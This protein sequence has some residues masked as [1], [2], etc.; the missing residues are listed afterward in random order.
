MPTVYGDY[1]RGRIGWFFGLSGAQ[2]GILAVSVLPVFWAVH[3]TAWLSAALFLV[4]WGLVAVVTVVPVRGRSATGWLAASTG[5]A[6]GG[7]AGWTRFRS[8]AASGRA[9]PSEAPDLPGVLQGVQIHD[10]P[11][12]GPRLARVAII[13][14]HAARTWAVTAG[15]VHPGIGLT[16][17]AGRDR[18]GVGLSGLLDQACRTELVDEILFI[19]RTVPEDGA[20]RDLWL[21]RHRRPGAPRL[22]RGVNDDL[23]QALAQA[24]VR[25]ETFATVVVPESRIGR[26][27]RESGGGLE[28]RARV[29]YG[30]VEEVEAQLRGPMAMTAVGWLSSAELAAACRTGFAPGDRA[31]I[32]DAL[33]AR[34]GGQDIC[35]DVPWAIAGPSGAD[36]AP[37]HYS[38]DAWHSASITIRLPARGAVMGALA[39][40]L[41]PS[42]PGERRSVLVAYPILRQATADRVTA[43]AEWA[44]DIGTH[45][46]ARAGIRPRA[47]QREEAARAHGMDAKLAGGN[48]MTRP[49]AVCTVTV[50]RTARIAEHARRLD[51]AARR[52]GFAPLRLDLSQD[53][54]FAASTIPLGVS[55]TRRGDA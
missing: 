52:A 36:P 46:R 34:D 25:T 45:L 14:D 28:G 38:H 50:P 7:L 27:A 12:R 13:Q 5:F 33:A 20:E 23:D 32:V 48:A 9:G 15:V 55:L 22:S 47:R 17:A 10:G 42:Q 11:P 2:L 6:V 18:L 26:D 30:L 8:A 53:T 39:P 35:P 40:L 51:A 24:G 4:V 44:A 54:A 3:Q 49:Y 41:A 19:V 1:S 29:L 37:R 31:G 43:G 21:A 16:E